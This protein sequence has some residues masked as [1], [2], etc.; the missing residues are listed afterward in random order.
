LIIGIFI[1]FLLDF[2]LGGLFM[3][4]KLADQRESLQNE[5]AKLKMKNG[6]ELCA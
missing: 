4:A 5:V 1:G 2:L 6:G 3:R